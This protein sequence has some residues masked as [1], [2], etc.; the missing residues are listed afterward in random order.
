MESAVLAWVAGYMS[1]SGL[2]TLSASQAS[3]AAWQCVKEKPAH[4]RTLPRVRGKQ[5][6]WEGLGR[7]GL[8]AASQRAVMHLE[9]GGS[10]LPWVDWGDKMAAPCSEGGPVI[11]ECDS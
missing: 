6:R 3:S 2:I 10:L 5:T 1:Y 8:G 9:Q 7:G 4:T 11:L